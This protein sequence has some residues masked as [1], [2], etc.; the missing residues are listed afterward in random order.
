MKVG[1]EGAWLDSVARMTGVT[2]VVQVVVLAG[3]ASCKVV[4]GK[5]RES[6]R[7]VVELV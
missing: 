5:N 7:N 6:V 3:E 2:G 1:E 4:L